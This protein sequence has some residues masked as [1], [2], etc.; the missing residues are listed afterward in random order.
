VALGIL[1]YNL[2][3]LA[4]YPSGIGGRLEVQRHHLGSARHR[5]AGERGCETH[6]VRQARS[7]I[8]KKMNLLCKDDRSGVKNCIHTLTRMTT[9]GLKVV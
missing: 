6:A 7:G 8:C 2:N 5:Q 3:G 9:T 1:T 4:R